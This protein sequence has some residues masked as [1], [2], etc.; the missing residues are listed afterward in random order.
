MKIRKELAAVA[1]VGLLAGAL[2]LPAAN[3]TAF[4]CGVGSHHCYGVAHY[5]PSNV[6]AFGVDLWTN[7]L[8][9]NTPSNRFATHETWY[10]TGS[11]TG[12]IE[13]GYIKGFIPDI[14][15]P[16]TH[17]RYWWGERYMGGTYYGHFISLASVSTWVNFSMYRN[18][19][20]GKW[21]I[22]TGGTLRGT[23]ASAY[24]IGGDVQVGG[25]TTDPY[26]YSYGASSNLQTRNASN[27]TWSFATLYSILQDA[28]VYSTT[29]S[30][31]YM[32]QTSLNNMCSSP[33]AAAKQ[34]AAAV[35]P[36]TAAN[37]R[38]EALAFAKAN[39]DASPESVQAVE[40]TRKA[41]AGNQ[42]VSSDQPVVSIQMKGDFTGAFASAAPGGE[43]VKGGVLSVTLDKKTGEITDWSIGSAR[44]DLKK[45]GSVKAL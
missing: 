19:S 10:N 29:G 20:T 41:V 38:S 32:T 28:D 37:V 8:H 45:L 7:C 30:G 14:D 40:T 16:S 11:G 5:K 31:S 15:N 6:N 17:F 1:A 22:Y 42:G 12:F 36:P 13:T 24:P 2:A 33:L 39:G 3:A 35:E 18:A 43:P 4:G 21:G 44:Q 26:V 34:T 23:T 25:E 27:G 9:L